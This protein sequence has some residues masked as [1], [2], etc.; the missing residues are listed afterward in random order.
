[1]LN[2]LK[3]ELNVKHILVGFG[4]TETSAAG[5]KLLNQVLDTYVII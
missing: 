4:L 2:R 5:T 1:M 3:S